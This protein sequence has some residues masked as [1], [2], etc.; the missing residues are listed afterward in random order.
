MQLEEILKEYSRVK[1]AGKLELNI[2]G[3]C[4]LHINNSLVVSLEKSLDGQGFYIYATIGS[5]PADKEKQIGMLALGGNL[6]GRETGRANIGFSDETRSLILF[7]YFEEAAI[8]F[9]SFFER[10]EK[11]VHYVSYWMVKLENRP[12]SEESFPFQKLFPHSPKDTKIFF[13]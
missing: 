3:V 6:F 2:S 9:A 1:N 5:I 13:A 8:T 4:R 11:F 10:F 12:K 7:E